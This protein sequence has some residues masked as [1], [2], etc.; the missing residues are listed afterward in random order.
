MKS[1]YLIIFGLLLSAGMVT[2][3][4]H[5]HDHD[6]DH[7]DHTHHHHSY[8]NNEIGIVNTPIYFLG[9][10][11]FAY[12]FH[13]HYVRNLDGTKL[14][15]G[16]GYERIFDEHKHNTIGIVGSYNPVGN[17]IINLSPGIAWEGVA[18]SELHFALH[19][20]SSYDFELGPIHLGP[21]LGL[22]YGEED[23][24]LGLGLHMGV[25]F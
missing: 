20:E 23:I 14:G 21:I 5:N 15:I 6:H 19:L 18:H 24:H 1:I 9:E 16:I 10:K 2:A 7:S 17:L 4:D 3:Q 12:G 13:V 25:G 8:H 11:E 22:S